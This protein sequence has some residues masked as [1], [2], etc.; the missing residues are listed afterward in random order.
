MGST[1][2]FPG[3]GPIDPTILLLHWTTYTGDFTSEA[4]FQEKCDELNSYNVGYNAME[5]NG[6]VRLTTPAG[7]KAYHCG[8]SEGLVGDDNAQAF[9]LSI[10]Y[11]SPSQNPRGIAGEVLNDFWWRAEDRMVQWWYPPIDGSMLRRVVLWAR[12]H[13][14]EQGWTRGA[15]LTHAQVNKTKNDIRNIDL[16][17]GTSVAELHELFVAPVPVS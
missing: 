13:F 5:W 7:Q 17:T 6:S 3:H 4:V 9:G 15:V 12:D 16:N 11:I 1:E 10:P 14:I 8:G 2:M